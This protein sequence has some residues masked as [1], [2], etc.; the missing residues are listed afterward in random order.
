MIAWKTLRNWISETFRGEFIDNGKSW[1]RGKLS[2]IRLRWIGIRSNSFFFKSEL[3]RLFVNSG[4]EKIAKIKLG[5]RSVFARNYYFSGKL[6]GYELRNFSKPPNVSSNLRAT[7]NV[8]K[9]QKGLCK[10]QQGLCKSQQS[11]CKKQQCLCKSQQCL[12]KKQQSLWKSQQSLWK[13]QQDNRTSKI[14]TSQ[15]I[16]NRR[17]IKLNDRLLLTA[18]CANGVAWDLFGNGSEY[19]FSFNLAFSF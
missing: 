15:S 13:K 3:E 17:K 16:I 2:G 12:C 7:K 4:F 19:L 11:L 8:K 6:S 14:G 10:K 1:L 18:V 5:S 9:S